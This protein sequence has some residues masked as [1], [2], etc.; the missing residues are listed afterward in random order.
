MGTRVGHERP[1]RLLLRF[2]VRTRLL[3][4]AAIAVLLSVP[5]CFVAV[6]QTLQDTTYYAAGYSE[7]NFRS[8]RR[9]M[10]ES[11]VIR[12]LGQPLRANSAVPQTSW[13]YGPS[14]LRVSD[15]GGM[16][17]TTGTFD[18]GRSYTGITADG[19][20]RVVH[21]SGGFLAVKPADLVGQTLGDVRKRFGKPH[22]VRVQRS[23]KYLTYSGTKVSG[24]YNWGIGLDAD[25]RV[26]R[27]VAGWYQD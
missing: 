16:W 10:H 14:T 12:L 20:G 15:D 26:N 8:I 11:E 5:S 25:G 3:V 6:W 1:S 7:R 9:G 23:S 2:R 19:A 18:A 13:Y 4:I 24:S 27:I 21:V 17:D 22:S